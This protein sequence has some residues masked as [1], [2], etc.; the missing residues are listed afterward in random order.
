MTDELMT[1]LLENIV[2]EHK[3]GGNT[4]SI[5]LIGSGSRGELDEFSDLDIHVIVRGERPP[6]QMFYRENRL[7]NINFLDTANR[8]AMFTDPWY[9]L[10]NLAAAREA[11][12][13]YDSDGWYTDLQQRARNFS[14]QSVAKDADIAVSWVLAENAEEVQK[15]LS[16]LSNNNLEKALY[17]TTGLILSLSNVSA[18]ANG[19]LCNSENKFWRAV[20]D[21]EPDVAWK[22]LYWTALGFESES[23]TTRAEA[24]VR[25]YQR[26]AL[27]YHTKLLAQHVPI[28]QHVCKLIEAR[29]V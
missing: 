2:A 7:V 5:V 22:K 25:L 24:A 18:L 10:K 27:L 12:I 4:L 19:V 11:T 29:G 14:W 8:E 1:K 23:V 6:D 20:R 3:H 16:G 28:I 15:I 26:S 21:A 9:T 13:L 17:A